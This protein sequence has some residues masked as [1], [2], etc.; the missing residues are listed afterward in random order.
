MKSIRKF[1]IAL[2]T[3]LL[4]FTML[5]RSAVC[6]VYAGEN[7]ITNIDIEV[8]IRDDGSAVVTQHWRLVTVKQ[9]L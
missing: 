1:T 7:H 5:S 6:K 2:F 4:L 9:N 3:V 8:I